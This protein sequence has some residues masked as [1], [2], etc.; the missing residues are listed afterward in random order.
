MVEVAVPE[1]RMLL[2]KSAASDVCPSNASNP[3]SSTNDG[4]RQIHRRAK[5]ALES[6]PSGYPNCLFMRLDASTLAVSA[7]VKPMENFMMSF[8]ALAKS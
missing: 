4:V 7:T 3:Q 5:R 6:L 2:Q 8:L 1:R